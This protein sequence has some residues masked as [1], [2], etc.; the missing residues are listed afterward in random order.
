VFQSRSFQVMSENH[1]MLLII[2]SLLMKI[3][4]KK[5]RRMLLTYFFV[6]RVQD[7]TMYTSICIFRFKVLSARLRILIVG[8]TY[9][10]HSH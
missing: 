10:S 4:T 5:S 2:E 1:F 9:V 7:R 3:M 8:V 6:V